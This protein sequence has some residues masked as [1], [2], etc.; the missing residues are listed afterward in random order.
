[1]A[2][3]TYRTEHTVE[4][5]QNNE[6]KKI[7]TNAL[8]KALAASIITTAIFSG[9]TAM[10]DTLTQNASPAD[11]I[12]VLDALHRFAWGMDTDNGDLIASAFAE[13]GVADFSPAA[14]K[15]G[16]TF[17]PLEGRDTIKGALTPFAQGLITS[18]TIGNARVEVNG[19]TAKVRALVEAQQI[20]VKDRSRGILLKNDYDVAL[21]RDGSQWVITRMT[22]DNV[23]ST[24]DVKVLTGE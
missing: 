22:I 12:A 6:R 7:M 5:V 1:V 11:H 17:P 8:K 14:K 23:W 24:G 13:N 16:I 18:H 19:D 15:I 3:C 10:T 4:D 2:N 9:A 20:S 21:S